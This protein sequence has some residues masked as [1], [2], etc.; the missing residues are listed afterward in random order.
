[1]DFSSSPF[2]LVFSTFRSSASLFLC[3]RALECK[4]PY[5]FNPLRGLLV[6]LFEFFLDLL[7]KYFFLF[8]LPTHPL[9]LPLV[10][11]VWHVTTC[12]LS[13]ELVNS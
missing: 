12:D 13:G 4:G 6:E 8:Q 1:M 2:S 9:K 10:K 11:T 7:E 3:I 5:L